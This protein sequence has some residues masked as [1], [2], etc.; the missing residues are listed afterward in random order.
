M[1]TLQEV[2]YGVTPIDVS[3]SQLISLIGSNG[4]IAGAFYNINDFQTIYDQPDFDSI[5]AP[6]YPVSTLSGSIEPL[7]VRA[8][9]TSEISNEALSTIYENDYILYDWNFQATEIMASPAKGMITRRITDYLINGKRNS[10]PYDSRAVLFKR[11]ET[12]SGS[13]IYNSYKDTGFASL[14]VPTFGNNCTDNNVGNFWNTDITSNV[15]SYPFILP[16]TVFG[17]NFSFN[18]IGNQ[19]FNIT[20][21]DLYCINNNIGNYFFNNLIGDNFQNNTIGNFFA[22][23]TIGDNFKQNKIG[24]FF[25][26]ILIGTIYSH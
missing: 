12:V 22:N 9:N 11:Y 7:I 6:K 10:T 18:N 2:K 24:S 21:G 13:G 25:G 8:V 19:C 3:Y 1:I 20:F 4:L 5:G 15:T 26:I 23:N 16:N 17:N 14:N